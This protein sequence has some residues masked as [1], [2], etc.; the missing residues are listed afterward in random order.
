MHMVSS[1][2][3]GTEMCI[4]FT[5]MRFKPISVLFGVRIQGLYK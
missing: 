3:G 2:K 5:V 4:G 1:D